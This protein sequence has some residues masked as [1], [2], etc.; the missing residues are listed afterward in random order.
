MIKLIWRFALLTAIA[1]GFAWLADRPGVLTLRWLGREIEMPLY[2]AVAALLLSLLVLWLIWT[3]LIR[4]FH[5][6]EAMGEYFRFRRTR[7]GYNSLSKGIIAAGAGDAALAAKHADVARRTLTDEPL[8]KLLEAQSAQLRGDRA[9]VKNAFEAMLTSPDTAALGLRGLYVE[10]RQSQ[11]WAKARDYAERAIKIS[12]TLAWASSGLLSLQSAAHD[13]AAAEATLETQRRS[14]AISAEAA[15]KLRAALLCARAIDA[16][17]GDRDLAFDLAVKAQKLD[18]TLVPAACVAAREHIRRE[19]T[20]RAMKI[21][22][23]SW[24]AMPHPDLAALAAHARAGDQ[25]E[26][27]LERV[28]SL[29]AGSPGG[30][31]GAFAHAR[32]A[33]EARQ[34]QEARKALLPFLKDRPQARLCVL[35]AEIEEGESGDKGRAREWLSRALRA[36][37]DPAWTIDGVIVPRWTPVSPLSGELA[38]CE[39]RAPPDLLPAP[40]EPE[41]RDEENPPPAASEPSALPPAEPPP[42]KP[43]AEA[44]PVP[45]SVAPPETAP[46]PKPVIVSISPERP[47]IVK[48]MR[49]PDDPGLGGGFEDPD[50][51]RPQRLLADG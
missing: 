43:A 10:A 7:K 16:E 19:A 38:P 39:W 11:D 13:W 6:P 18:P 22:R 51:P 4:L 50:V 23:R 45:E 34:W 21:L 35:M 41:I 12:P 42:T 26:A 9:A 25:P 40:P 3:V 49:P 48:S 46:P 17:E 31:E 30:L 8:V 1:A 28:R 14:G 2:I 20:R 37:R 5:A 33:V 47:V 27:R 36:P 44:I 32:A 15:G 24:E 29:L